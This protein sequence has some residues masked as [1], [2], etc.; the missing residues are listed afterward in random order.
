MK[1]IAYILQHPNRGEW[2]D[3]DADHY[4][5]KRL[6]NQHPREVV[7]MYWNEVNEFVGRGGG[8]ELW[9]CGWCAQEN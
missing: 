4:F 5:S 9:I 8:Q 1:G 7:E 2:D 6:V 3:I